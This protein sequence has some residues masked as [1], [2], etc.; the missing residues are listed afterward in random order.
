MN[1]GH[2]EDKAREFPGALSSWVYSEDG[3]D[4]ICSWN[5]HGF[6]EEPGVKDETKGSQS[7]GR[8]ELPL[9]RWELVRQEN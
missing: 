8:T 3:S 1:V 9:L 4:G 6:G 5:G 2:V 7:T